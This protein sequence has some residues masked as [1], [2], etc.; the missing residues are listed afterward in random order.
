MPGC[1]SPLPCT[2]CPLPFSRLPARSPRLGTW[3]P[4][5]HLAT[6][7]PVALST[8][9]PSKIPSS[10]RRCDAAAVHACLD[11]FLSCHLSIH[12]D[13]PGSCKYCA[14]HRNFEKTGW[15]RKA[16]CRSAVA[17]ARTSSIT[18]IA[19]NDSRFLQNRVLHVSFDLLHG[20]SVVD[21]LH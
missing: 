20:C 9:K 15:H 16:C 3:H 4:T 2:Y 7:C 12:M 19:N 21:C 13:M 5:V 11:S 1:I 14:K 8:S 10:W 6:K 18:S 17:V